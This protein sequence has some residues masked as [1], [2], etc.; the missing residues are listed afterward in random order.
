MAQRKDTDPNHQWDVASVHRVSA[1][2][3]ATTARYGQLYHDM[4][5]A[6]GWSNALETYCS[7]CRRPYDDVADQPC[8][9]ADGWEHLI[10]GPRG[11]RKRLHDHDCNLFGCN[12]TL[13][14]VQAEALRRLAA[15]PTPW[16]RAQ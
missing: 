7:Q 13:T 16:R 5:D 14:P 2:D 10:G 6:A 4:L 8:E 15:D 12:P 1:A 9:A 3:A 11:R